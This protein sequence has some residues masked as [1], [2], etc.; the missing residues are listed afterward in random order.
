MI[1]INGVQ[2]KLYIKKY[3]KYNSFSLIYVDDDFKIEKPIE[4][5]IE[6]DYLVGTLNHLSG[7][8]LVGNNVE[9]ENPKTGDNVSYLIMTLV[10]SGLG[11]G[12]LLKKRNE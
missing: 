11:L 5:K 12:I 6:D 4:L 7:Y 1:I 10:I 2:T 9:K 8:A 3:K